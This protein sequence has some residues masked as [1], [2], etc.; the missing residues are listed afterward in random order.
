MKVDCDGRSWAKVDDGSGAIMKVE[1]AQKRA[2]AEIAFQEPPEK[3]R[4]RE[5]R[6]RHK[7]ETEAKKK[8]EEEASKHKA[9]AEAQAKAEKIAAAQELK[10]QK[11]AAAKAKAENFRFLGRGK[12]FDE[13]LAMLTK[14]ATELDRPLQ[15][16]V[17]G[18][19]GRADPSPGGKFEQPRT[20]IYGLATDAT[21]GLAGYMCITEQELSKRLAQGEQAIIDEVNDR[22]KLDQMKQQLED[23]RME[24]E[25][26]RKKKKGRQ[27]DVA[28]GK[29]G[30]GTKTLS[31][32]KRNGEGDGG[33]GGDQRVSTLSRTKTTMLNV[34]PPST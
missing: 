21:L 14:A 9:A 22:S 20:L 8:K 31:C 10:R 5:G 23:L 4:E 6:R 13:L 28:G 2:A 7:A 16:T 26:L 24:L 29:R 12:V 17:A 3:R 15:V 32:G 34:F 30:R 33:D 11:A 18:P 19:T 1:E 25:L 27:L